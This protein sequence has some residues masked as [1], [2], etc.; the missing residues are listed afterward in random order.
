MCARRHRPSVVRYLLAALSICWNEMR[1]SM[2]LFH[3]SFW[4]FVC[5]AFSSSFLLSDL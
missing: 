3:S 5:T 1:S 2:K 4:F